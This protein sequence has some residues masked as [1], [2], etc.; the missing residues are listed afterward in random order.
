MKAIHYYITAALSAIC[1]FASCQKPQ[2][3]QISGHIEGFAS[4]TLFIQVEAGDFSEHGYADTILLN[5]G[6]FVYKINENSPKQVYIYNRPEAGAPLVSISTMLLPGEYATLNG[7][8]E[9]LELGGA[10]FYVDFNS[11]NSQLDENSQKY[12]KI[13]AGFND[14]IANIPT[15]EREAF[16]ARFNKLYDEMNNASENIIRQF[17]L[18]HCNN[19]VAAYVL[20]YTSGETFNELKDAISTK[21][22]EGPLAQYYKYWEDARAKEWAIKL[23]YERTQPGA[24]ARDFTVKGTEGQDIKLSDFRGKYLVLDFWGSWC[25]WCIKGIPEMKEYYQKYSDKVEFL[26]IACNDTDEK[27]KEALKEYQMPWVQAINGTGDND[28]PIQ[29][30]V[31]GYPTKIVID[32][33]G[34]IYKVT[35]GENP[36]FYECLDSLFK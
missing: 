34:V 7:T 10:D 29:Y 15:E 18:D 3:C 2:D 26:S 14:S 12:Q 1:L 11:L 4:D 8:P 31:S 33:D 5:N 19:D 24:T 28:V 27:W 23:A 22:K 20:P 6:D 21:V 13:F 25:H 17:I 36:D 32:P 16:V 9:N 30:G 35:S